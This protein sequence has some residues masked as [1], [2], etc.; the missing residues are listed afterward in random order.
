MPAEQI[1]DLFPRLPHPQQLSRLRE[2]K[3]EPNKGP[4]PPGHIALFKEI[5][6]ARFSDGSVCPRL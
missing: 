2:L 1:R 3:E 4:L 6:G 5:R